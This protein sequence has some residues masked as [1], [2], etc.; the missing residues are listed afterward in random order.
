MNQGEKSKCEITA[1]AACNTALL[2]PQMVLSEQNNLFIIFIP[3]F[4]SD[5][6]ENDGPQPLTAGAWLH[7]S[8]SYRKCLCV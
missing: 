3:D 7:Y 4:L 2:R 1:P 6:G 5:K 8:D